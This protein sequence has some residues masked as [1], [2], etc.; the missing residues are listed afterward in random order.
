MSAGLRS[1]GLYGEHGDGDGRDEQPPIPE[2]RPDHQAHGEGDQ[3]KVED[4]VALADDG[5]P[6][7]RPTS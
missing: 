3:E 4:G 6:P 2:D 7:S 5:R 1:E